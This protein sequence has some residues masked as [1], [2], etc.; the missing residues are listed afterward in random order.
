[1]SE[2]DDA[3]FAGVLFD[4]AGTLFDDRGVVTPAGLARC[5]ERRGIALAESSA[6]EM[7][8]Q[9]LAYANA[10]ER[11]AAKNG[12][13][14]SQEAHRRVWTRL[15]RES[16]SCPAELV[17]SFY[18]CLTDNDSWRPY[19]DVRSVLESLSDAG[20]A[21]GVLS[22]IGWD[23]RPAFD[24]AGILSLFDTVVLSFEEGLAKPDPALF[25]RACERLATPPA[26][27]LYVGD[28]HFNDGAAV[29]AGLSAYLLASDRSGRRP[30]GLDVVLGCVGL[31]VRSLR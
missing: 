8:E 10:P 13:D 18:D 4:F 7:I 16:G 14:L 1:M 17:E 29:L 30:R 22:N 2:L 27:V 20:V 25:L 28:D 12:S 15:I 24:R 3:A 9:T 11:R 5:A 26:R 19:P 31:S 6:A 21:L 23:I